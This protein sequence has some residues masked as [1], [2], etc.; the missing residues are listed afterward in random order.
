MKKSFIRGLWGIYSKGNNLIERRFKMDYDIK[1]TLQNKYSPPSVTYVY[2]EDN[3]KYLKDLGVNDLK[4]VQKEPFKF[5]LTTQQYRHKLEI[6]RL[7]MEDFDEIVYIDWDCIAKSKLPSDF[8]EVMG[9]KEFC[10]AN[11]QQYKRK[12][13][14]WRKND[15]RKLPNSGFLYIRDL[16]FTEEVIACW[17]R[18]KGNS[19]EPPIA[20]ALDNRYG[21]WI[22][23][24]KYWELHE[25]EFCN[26][27]H[28]SAYPNS[29]I[30]T[31]RIHFIH[32]QG[33]PSYRYVKGR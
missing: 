12:K 11:L 21:G 30:N 19:D 28:F 27:A 29:K 15:V 3:F 17:D 8:W 4:L 13:C 2:G 20:K 22:G 26:L 9:K 25:A 14:M 32:N 24:D 5:D 33:M 1:Q 18:S 23:M 6:F 7:A 31:K 16:D 10:Q